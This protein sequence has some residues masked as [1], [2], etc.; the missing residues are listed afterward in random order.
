MAQPRVYRDGMQ[1]PGFT[2]AQAFTTGAIQLL[3]TAVQLL[4]ASQRR[5]NSLLNAAVAHPFHR[6]TADLEGPGNILAPH[7]P[8]PLGLIAEEQDAGDRKPHP[9][10]TLKLLVYRAVLIVKSF[11][12]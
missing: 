8:I 1:C 6:R 5:L 2:A 11:V 12:G 4:L 9:S 10:I 7:G 3:L